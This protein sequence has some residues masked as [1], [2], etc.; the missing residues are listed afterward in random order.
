MFI[1]RLTGVYLLLVLLS[2]CGGDIGGVS[3][4]LNLLNRS[5]STVS[6]MPDH[7]DY[8]KLSGKEVN[9]RWLHHAKVWKK[10]CRSQAQQTALTAAQK[11]SLSKD[12]DGVWVLSLH[13]SG[14][15]AAEQNPQGEPWVTNSFKHPTVIGRSNI[16]QK[17]RWSFSGQSNLFKTGTLNTLRA[18]AVFY[19]EI[20]GS[21]KVK[22]LGEGKSFVI[23]PSAEWSDFAFELTVPENCTRMDL[24][25]SLY[26]AGE[27]R[28][29]DVRLQKLETRKEATLLAIPW[30]FLDNTYCV[31]SGEAALIKFLPQNEAK[32]K[33]KSPRMRIT[34]MPGF[35]I[36]GGNDRTP[37]LFCKKNADNTTVAEFSLKKY[38]FPQRGYKMYSKPCFLIRTSL[39]PS[40][41]LYK[42]TYQ[43]IDEDYEGVI[44]TLFLKVIAPEK[45]LPPQEFVSGIKCT[46]E[47]NFSGKLAGNMLELVSGK[48][49][50]AIAGDNTP[51]MKLA[52]KNKIIRIGQSLWIQNAYR[53][54]R[55]KNRTPESYFRKA[56]GK[57]FILNKRVQTCPVEVYTRGSYYRNE[58]LPLLKEILITQ[59]YA[60][61]IMPNWEMHH[62]DFQGC[63]CN[64]CRDE[65][66]IFMQGSAT[67]D[68]IKAAWPA[69]ILQKWETPWQRFRSLQHSRIC[70]TLAE[71]V[72]EIGKKAGKKSL[73][74]PA[75]AWHTV[76]ENDK[77][78]F[79][80]YMPR[81]YMDKLKCLL[82]WGPYIFTN[83]TEKYINYPGLH[84][85]VWNAAGDVK[86]YVSK[87]VPDPARRPKLLAMPQGMQ[88]DTWITEPEA[89]AFENLCFFLQ[90]W[91]GSIVYYFPRSYDHRYWNALANCNSQIA[92][93]E[94][95]VMRGKLLKDG[96]SIEPLTSLP[97]PVFPDFWNEGGDFKKRLP[98]LKKSAIVQTRLFKKGQGYLAAVGN[99]WQ[100]S[101]IFLKLK[102]RN[103]KKDTF[104]SIRE[105]GNHGKS[106]GSF[107]GRELAD[108]ILIMTGALRWSLLE[109]TP[110]RHPAEITRQDMQKL[111]RERRMR[112]EQRCREEAAY[113]AQRQRM[114]SEDVPV[115]DF[116]SIY[117][118]HISGV[119]LKAVQ[120]DGKDFLQITARN[121]TAMI[122]PSQGGTIKSLVKNGRELVNRELAIGMACDGIWYPGRMAFNSL[123]GC[124]ISG[125]EQEK[126]SVVVTLSRH[127]SHF[128][129]SSLPGIKLT[130]KLTFHQDRIGVQTV[131]HNDAGEDIEIAF[132]YN[133]LPIQLSAGEGRAVLQNDL[134]F[135]ASGRKMATYG[136]TVSLV[137]F[138]A[139]DKDI[140]SVKK[141]MI[142]YNAAPAE[143]KLEGRAG[144]MRLACQDNAYGIV[145][146]DIGNSSTL[147]VL[148]RKERIASGAEAS[149]GIW[150]H[151]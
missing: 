144:N 6:E 107:S 91:D 115:N 31:N 116:K 150:W 26:G 97:K 2:C 46:H 105:L 72:A 69:E 23:K 146:W 101:E 73:F 149:Y 41:K 108:G 55:D 148:F 68:E 5:N 96:L 110:G 127:L 129:K 145:F 35:E 18:I 126:S 63:F 49:I 89:I 135:S 48:G 86:N 111:F 82:P 79:A 29:K 66:I 50:N 85:I 143:V 87:Y 71:D 142:F 137:R 106:H 4:D 37:M 147:E 134:K 83:L 47:L 8:H 119:S 140:D 64:R 113:L 27:M 25:F 84:L 122:D 128:D 120:C 98:G 28:V 114:L 38:N 58:V 124:K 100:N 117:D 136:S 118:I 104:Y 95:Y 123:R 45:S 103:L 94:K 76:I 44:K 14:D 57:I 54:G 80:Q 138:G 67:A 151:L 32:V 3:V 60:E 43:M 93:A 112:I 62:H 131:V 52:G 13:T 1:K 42:L 132:R 19:E 39:P 33:V 90:G 34:V 10:N 61:H 78:H 88:A 92:A 59:D 21:K 30:S 74:I 102:I 22:K 56:D 65:F 77:P 36:L 51:V 125:I 16:P 53:M 130:R 121:Y 7:L 11:G 20:P 24:V 75:I 15:I 40:E 12:A 17:Y 70:T 139:A 81:D 99:F 141:D 9:K 133:S 109:I